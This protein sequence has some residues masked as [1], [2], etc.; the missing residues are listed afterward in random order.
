MNIER[1]KSFRIEIALIS[2]AAILLEVS[3]T[4]IFSFKLWYYFTFLVLGIA[5]LGLGAGGIFVAILPR[6]RNLDPAKLIARCSLSAALAI[7]FG[8]AFVAMMQVNTIDLGGNPIEIVKLF[9]VC[10]VLFLPFLLIGIM[11]ST[12]L[13]SRVEDVNRLYFADLVA[14]GLGCAL[15]VPLF[16]TVGPPATVL[17]G[18]LIVGLAGITVSWD[19][20]DWTFGANVAISILLA[21]AILAPNRIPD[22]VVDAS[23]TMSPQKLVDRSVLFS[24]WSSV[25]RVDVVAASVA[26][27]SYIIHHDGMAGS[28]F[29]RFDGDYSKLDGVRR[30]PSAK[31]FAVLEPG[32]DVLIIGAAGGRQI[33]DALYFGA[34]SVTAVDLNPVTVSLLSDRFAD[35]TGDIANDPRVTLV[36]AEGRSFL[37]RSASEFDLIWL[38]A[39]DSYAAASAASAGALVL[40]ESYLY[41]VEMVTEGLKHLRKDGI[42]CA[43]FGEPSL[44]TNPNR[45][46]RYVATAREA[47]RRIGI[48]DFSRHIIVSTARGMLPHSTTILGRNEFSPAD[49]ESY[50]QALDHVPGSELW[51]PLP[52]NVAPNVVRRLISAPDAQLPRL[53]DDYIFDIRPVFDNAPFF[54]HFVRF[55]D[56]FSDHRAFTTLESGTGERAL[57]ALLAFAVLF[58]AVFLLIPTVAIRNVWKEIPH[59]SQAG[60]YFASLG[61]GFMLF[62][63]CLIQRLTL[64][65]GYP[66]YSLTVTLFA[67]LV[68]SGIGSLI[69][70]RYSR[71]RNRSLS[72]LLVGL[73]LSTL[74]L[75]FGVAPISSLFSNVGLGVRVVVSIAL[76][77]PLG[78]CLGAFMPLGITSITSV[79]THDKEYVAWAWSVNGFFSVVSSVLAMI[80]GMTI[81][82]Q[83]VLFVALAVYV[84]G[85]LALSRFPEPAT[86]EA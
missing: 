3:M 62:E 36:N 42:I 81:G 46:P 52:G 59:K 7:P 4:R 6:L 40:A 86:D 57:L 80:L 68:F 1:V 49:L 32:A 43:Q 74:L 83:A 28:A 13:G 15:C 16:A 70:S 31:P 14:A 18:A 53:F 45:A 33:R 78:L 5:L 10:L 71:H 38:V 82:F 12:I 48:T 23:K 51:H 64:F 26:A 20:R 60:T 34:G 72:L 21:A 19:D 77:A 85:C 66:S 41:T 30:T 75:Q 25:F 63:V 2:L 39:P 65:L 73:A 22:P 61:L 11:L 29:W 76:L 17:L 58:A 56:T 47:Y 8:Y 44:H 54:W 79:T 69:S 27:S 35:Y 55:R 50:R 24:G 9:V 84:V 67:L 37:E